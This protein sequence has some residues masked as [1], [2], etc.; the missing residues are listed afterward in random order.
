M[1]LPSWHAQPLLK[2]PLCLRTA[3]SADAATVTSE[4]VLRVAGLARVL[5]LN[6]CEGVLPP[7]FVPISWVLCKQGN[8]FHFSFQHSFIFAWIQIVLILSLD[9]F[10]A[11]LMKKK[12]IEITYTC[13]SPHHI[14]KLYLGLNEIFKN[15]NIWPSAVCYLWLTSSPPP[16][17]RL[18]SS[19]L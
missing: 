15:S 4:T 3:H 9:D 7:A 14:T 11:H 19:N 12:R 8:T 10:R 16:T 13:I 2:V 17:L 6:V 5:S 18:P 1:L